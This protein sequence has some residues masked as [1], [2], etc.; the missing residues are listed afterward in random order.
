M[1]DRRPISEGEQ[2]LHE[3]L[4]VRGIDPAFPGSVGET[5]Q[6]FKEFV[7]IPFETE[8]ADSDGVL[9]Q[10]GIFDFYGRDEFYLEFLRQFEVLDEDGEHDRFEQLHCEFRFPASEAT[11][12]FGAFDHWWFPDDPAQPWAEFVAL[13]ERRPEFHALRSIPP[14]AA[15]IGQEPV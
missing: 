9:Y 14:Q 2:T 6:V 11:R 7:A 8:G 3:L 15:K 12:S 4:R 10:A 1:N 13:V 5:W